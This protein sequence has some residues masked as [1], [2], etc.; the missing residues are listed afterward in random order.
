DGT[1]RNARPLFAGGPVERGS[2]I[3]AGAPMRADRD[4]DGCSGLGNVGREPVQ[5]FLGPGN[6]DELAG[7]SRRDVQTR[8]VPNI[9]DLAVERHFQAIRG[10]GRT[11]LDKP[12]G[13]EFHARNPVT[14]WRCDLQPVT[15]P[16]Y[17]KG[18]LRRLVRR[19][20]DLAVIYQR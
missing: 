20:V 8:Y 13:V 19:Q 15:S 5:H 7:M 10:I 1:H 9:I 12:P 16:A 3:G 4:V 18:E 6:D 17:R 14:V 2:E 11:A